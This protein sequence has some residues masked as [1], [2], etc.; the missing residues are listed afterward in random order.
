[1]SVMCCDVK[2][3]LNVLLRKCYHKQALGADFHT[4]ITHN[5]AS[6]RWVANVRAVWGRNF[7][8]LRQGMSLLQQAINSHQ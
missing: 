7:A 1:M 3:C 8:S 2:Y 4:V 5:R 6:E